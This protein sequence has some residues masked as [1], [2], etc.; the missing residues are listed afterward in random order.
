MYIESRKRDKCTKCNKKSGFWKSILLMLAFTA[1][2][3]GGLQ[4]Y[5]DADTR[6]TLNREGLDV[7]SGYIMNLENE[8]FDTFQR[9]SNWAD[10]VEQRI[11]DFYF[12]SKTEAIRLNKTLSSLR[13]ETKLIIQA[14]HKLVEDLGSGKMTE[15]KIATA[16]SILQ[17]RISNTEEHIQII[18]RNP[19]KLIEKVI[20]PTVGISTQVNTRYMRG[21][22]V[23]YKKIKLVDEKTGLVTYRY[24]GFTAYHVWEQMFK[25][26]EE[27]K[28]TSVKFDNGV[29]I[30]TAE[31]KHKLLIHYYGGNSQRAT[32]FIRNA[33]FIYRNKYREVYSIQ[34]DI[35]V[36]TFVISRGD[37]A[38]AELATDIEVDEALY[39][40]R[41]IYV[42]GIAIEKVPSLYTGIIANPKQKHGDILFQA[43]AYYGQSGGPIFDAT[44]LKVI[45]IT[46]RMRVHRSGFNAKSPLSNTMF[47][48]SIKDMRKLWS[49]LAPDKESRVLDP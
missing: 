35:T 40:G 34:E 24:Y 14:Q 31:K 13:E 16:I 30:K 25:A 49:L 18:M 9:M 7:I 47:G 2:T 26:N 5:R 6:M 37:L 23:L 27:N 32:F 44:S 3:L 1:S 17:N 19:Y 8:T 33:E 20:K 10:S 38:V 42:T 28:E 15:K 43:F 4:A 29:T 36:F 41:R 22:G 39:Y 45:S 48:C 46:Q 21:S 12:E 11:V